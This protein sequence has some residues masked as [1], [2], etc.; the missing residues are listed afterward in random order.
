[1][2]NNKP[3][4]AVTIESVQDWKWAHSPGYHGSVPVLT[5]AERR[6]FSRLMD[7]DSPTRQQIALREA[8]RRKINY[9]ISR[10]IDCYW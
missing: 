8:L 7:T 3:L 6:T 1:M 10:E 9:R 5:E 2:T 4:P